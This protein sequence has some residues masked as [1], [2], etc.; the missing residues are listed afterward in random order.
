MDFQNSVTQLEREE[1]FQLNSCNI[2]KNT[3]SMFE[4]EFWHILKKMQTKM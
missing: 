3:F 1:N 2:S 4:F